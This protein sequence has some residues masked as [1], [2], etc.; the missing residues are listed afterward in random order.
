ML[1][2]QG[3]QL[4]RLG[5][6]E[7]EVAAL[8]G[9]AQLILSEEDGMVDNE[10]LRHAVEQAR[11]DGTAVTV[12]TIPSSHNA[13]REDPYLLVDVLCGIFEQVS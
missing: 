8:L 6:D 1:L 13:E 3:R 11:L 9:G 12:H 10:R 5:Y 2:E 7:E 4:L